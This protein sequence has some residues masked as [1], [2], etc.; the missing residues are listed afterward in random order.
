M[1]TERAEPL[2]RTLADAGGGGGE[3]PR[4][5]FPRGA[6]R[7]LRPLRGH[8]RPDP[9][10][11][12]EI[13]E[14]RAAGSLFDARGRP[15]AAASGAVQVRLIAPRTRRSKA[16]ASLIFIVTGRARAGPASCPRAASS[17]RRAKSF[18]V[19]SS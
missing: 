3:V 15:A 1:E 8:Q 16:S 5:G 12:A 17:F 14:R 11:R 6:A 4:R 9:A 18:S 13:L 10:R 2:Q 7:R 19:V